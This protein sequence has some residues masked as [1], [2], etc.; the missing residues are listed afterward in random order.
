M[1]KTI[2]YNPDAVDTVREGDLVWISVNNEKYKL[3]DVCECNLAIIIEAYDCDMI[4]EYKCFVVDVVENGEI[5]RCG[6]YAEHIIENYTFK[7]SH[8][9]IMSSV[10]KIEN[11]WID[12]TIQ[13]YMNILLH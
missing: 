1:I 6:I 2:A 13:P 3:G 10:K 9:R 11:A 5:K 4:P 7:N 8:K 12:Y